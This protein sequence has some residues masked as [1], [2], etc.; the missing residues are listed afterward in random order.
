MPNYLFSTVGSPI[1]P[2]AGDP[3]PL[4]AIAAGTERRITPPP[5]RRKEPQQ[6]GNDLLG[7]PLFLHRRDAPAMN[8][9]AERASSSGY[10]HRRPDRNSCKKNGQYKGTSEAGSAATRFLYPHLCGVLSSMKR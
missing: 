8:E 7:H 1:P 9:R 6:E 2:D 4:A 3:S 5:A 10:D